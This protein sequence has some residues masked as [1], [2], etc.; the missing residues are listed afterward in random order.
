ME[1][2]KDI[3]LDL[4]RSGKT[5]LFSTHVMEQAEK[6]CDNIC[7]ISHGKKVIDGQLGNVKAQFGKN[8]IQLDIEG[9]GGFVASL[10]GIKSVTEFNNYLELRLNDNADTNAILKA[11]ADR[12]TV[13]RFDIVEPSLYDIFIDMAKVDPSELEDKGEIDHV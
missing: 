5:I 3:V 10:P 11:V 8:S 1:L 12:V 7:M 2:M 6:L 4:K 9:D 13:R